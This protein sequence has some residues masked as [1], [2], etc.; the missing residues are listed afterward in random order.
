MLAREMNASQQHRRPGT[1][2]RRAND[3]SYGQWWPWPPVEASVTGSHAEQA[4]LT[5]TRGGQMYRMNASMDGGRLDEERANAAVSGVSFLRPEAFAR[6]LQTTTMR[7][8]A[9]RKPGTA[10]DAA[11]SAPYVDSASTP[12]PSTPR[13]QKWFK[14]DL[15][16]AHRPTSSSTPR[17]APASVR[18]TSAA[19]GAP[20]SAS[21]KRQLHNTFAPPSSQTN[22]AVDVVRYHDLL[23]GRAATGSQGD[24]RH[25]NFRMNDAPRPPIEAWVS[26]GGA[27]RASGSGTRDT[28][29][30]V[31]V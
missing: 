24:K 2:R 1:P 19:A 12:R 6:V 22:V 26:R 25:S 5:A 15:T 16:S 17:E 13:H 3:Y 27:S 10:W 9:M 29:N 14:L 4:G 23:R 7:G 28:S 30:V 21:G 20:W 31:R 18:A 11:S 8:G